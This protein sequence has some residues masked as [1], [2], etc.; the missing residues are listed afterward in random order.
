MFLNNFSRVGVGKLKRPPRKRSC[1]G[2][3]LKNNYWKLDK[4]IF[5]YKVPDCLL[6]D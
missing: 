6:C 5:K 3:N 2:H 1:N 4:V